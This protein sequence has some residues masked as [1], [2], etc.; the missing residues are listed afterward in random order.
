MNY[1]ITLTLFAVVVAMLWFGPQQRQSNVALTVF[2]AWW[3]P[4]VLLSF[5]FVGRLWCAVCPF[6]IYGEVTQGFP[7]GCFQAAQALAKAGGRTL[8]RLVS[9]WP[10]CPDSDLGRSV[11]SGEYR[12]PVGLPAD[13]DYRRG[14]D[15]LGP[16]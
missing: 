8:G 16:V 4:L 6:M 1:G 15:F 14:D 12:L 2:W 5:P 7:N 10:V 3:W 11:A 9:V 13:A